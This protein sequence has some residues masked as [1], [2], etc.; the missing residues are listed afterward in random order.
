MSTP[1]LSRCRAPFLPILLLA[2]TASAATVPAVSSA[3]LAAPIRL[4]GQADEWAGVPR[5][6]D[7]KSGAELAFQNDARYIYILLALNKPESVQSVEATGMTVLGRPGGS[8]KPAKGVL[9]LH[10][11]IDADAYI[12]WRESQGA[13]LTEAEKVEIRKTSRHPISLAFATDETGSSYGPLRKQTDVF[14]PDFGMSR[15]AAGMVCEFR[16]PLAS[17][18]TVPG[19]L[20][21]TPGAAIRVTLGW[22]GTDRKGL[23]TK[24][25]RESPNSKSGYQSGTGR[26]WG[27]EFLDSFDTMSNPSPSTK[28]FSFAVDVKLADER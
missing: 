17:P 7:L 28:K 24:G 10:G 15:N 1:S 20:G 11:E 4:D 26:T 5:I 16:I 6:A 14:P 23:S 13:V 8:G 22:G 9:F 18:N 27:Q 25:S 21:G 19:G 3:R 12:A 2:A